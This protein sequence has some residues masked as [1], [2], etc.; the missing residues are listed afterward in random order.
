MSDELKKS[1][2]EM[3]SLLHGL[4]ASQDEAEKKRNALDEEKEEKMTSELLKL[5]EELEKNRA[6]TK[7]LEEALATFSAKETQE[8]VTDSERKDA[9]AHYIRKNDKSKLMEIKALSTDESGSAG[10]L[11]LSPEFKGIVLAKEFETSPMRML[12]NVESGSAGAIQFVLDDGETSVE[13]LGEGAAPTVSDDPDVGIKTITAHELYAMPKI[14]NMMI[15]DASVDIVGWVQGKASQLMGRAENTR[16]VTGNGVTS[17][18]G[19]LTYANYASAGVY[20][21]GAIEQINSGSSGAFTADGLIDLQ[22]ALKESYQINA[23]WMMKRSSFTAIRKLKDAENQYLIGMG[24]NG[25]DG[26]TRLTLLDKPVNFADDVTA[27]GANSLSAVYGDFKQAYT[28]YD[29]VGISVLVDPYSSKGNVIFQVR[30]RVGGDVV[31]FEAVKIQKL[32]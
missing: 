2:N 27:A 10:Y 19:I 11:A 14:T 30:K 20:E 18:R 3:Q 28:I 29:R 17:P 12:A 26:Q 15:E 32:A 22:G 5:N 21:R 4:K 8:G 1:I 23:Q 25:L 13:W 6:E 24:A 9:L 7:A 16:F 31:N